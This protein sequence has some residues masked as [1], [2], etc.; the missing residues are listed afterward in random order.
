MKI[1]LFKLVFFISLV[2]ILHANEAFQLDTYCFEKNKSLFL[3]KVSSNSL[4]LTEDAVQDNTGGY[5]DI[6][7]D[8]YYIKTTDKVYPLKAKVIRLHTK[9]VNQLNGY[10]DLKTLLT[11]KHSN[12][13]QLI[14]KIN[15]EKEMNSVKNIFHVHF[16]EKLFNDAYN[17]CNN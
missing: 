9:K 14:Q 2:N 16:N 7:E 12:N 6:P 5:V 4:H 3:L 8:S 1:F 15:L 13:L 10:I 11:I 17:Q